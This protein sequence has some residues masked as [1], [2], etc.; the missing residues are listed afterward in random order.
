MFKVST[1]K[2]TDTQPFELRNTSESPL[3]TRPW[4]IQPIVHNILNCMAKDFQQF[5]T[6]HVNYSCIKLH[7]II[8]FDL[9]EHYNNK[10][11]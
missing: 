7:T 10:F 11:R 9:V 6:N 8:H 2:S 4:Y 1:T 3:P 5:R